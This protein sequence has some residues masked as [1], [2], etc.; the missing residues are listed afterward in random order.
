MSIVCFRYDD[1]A[2]G[3]L[4][5]MAY[6][7][8]KI[9]YEKRKCDDILPSLLE[10]GTYFMFLPANVLAGIVLSDIN[11]KHRDLECLTGYE[12]FN[13]FLVGFRRYA[14]LKQILTDTDEFGY[15]F[16]VAVSE[17]DYDYIQPFLNN[18]SRLNFFKNLYYNTQILGKVSYIFDQIKTR[19]DI[20]NKHFSTTNFYTYEYIL[21]NTFL[22]NEF[23]DTASCSCDFKIFGF[24]MRVPFDFYIDRA[25][26]LPSDEYSTVLDEQKEVYSGIN[27]KL[28]EL[29]V[30]SF[31]KK[32]LSYVPLC[33]IR[34]YEY[35]KYGTGKDAYL[36]LTLQIEHDKNVMIMNIDID[37]REVIA[38]CFNIY[39]WRK[40][41]E[42][43]YTLTVRLI[44]NVW[45]CDY[46]A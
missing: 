7:L 30:A 16:C 45:Y 39:K 42:Y 10:R 46:Y 32:E 13:Y 21:N 38:D 26:A 44:D 24:F 41:D 14:K 29:G 34:K 25:D 3:V 27:D 19:A 33:G 9:F 17:Y 23:V 31:L 40:N 15:Y 22:V 6:D 36:E 12:S 20:I 18:S 2:F 37:W 35:V 43:N 8:Q 1:G 5:D 28:W 11:K 4:E